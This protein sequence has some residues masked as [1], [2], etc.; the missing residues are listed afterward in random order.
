MEAYSTHFH[1]AS[2]KEALDRLAKNEETGNYMMQ[3]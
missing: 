2:S 3:I 1:Q